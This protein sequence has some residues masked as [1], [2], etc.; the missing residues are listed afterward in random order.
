MTTDGLRGRVLAHEGTGPTV[1][2][3][4]GEGAGPERRSRKEGQS[5]SSF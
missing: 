5:C 1:A 3:A 2:P 4:L